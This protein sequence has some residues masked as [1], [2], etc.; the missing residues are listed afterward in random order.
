MRQLAVNTGIISG[1]GVAVGTPALTSEAINQ[2][3]FWGITLGG[4]VTIAAAVSVFLLCAYNLWKLI[5]HAVDRYREYK[6][7]KIEEDRVSTQ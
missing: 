1:A 6:R 5:S 2:L 4:W 7:I 3:V